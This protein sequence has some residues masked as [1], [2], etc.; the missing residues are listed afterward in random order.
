MDPL[1]LLKLV[2]STQRSEADKLQALAAMADAPGEDFMRGVKL[3]TQNAIPAF[4]L[5]NGGLG[6]M[7]AGTDY[8]I[9]APVIGQ[10]SNYNQSIGQL[11]IGEN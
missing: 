5:G 3:P 6:S 7:I 4:K 2:N 1:D 10:K 8:G 9:A 11:L